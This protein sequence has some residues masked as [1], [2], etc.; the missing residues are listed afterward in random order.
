MTE[1]GKKTSQKHSKFIQITYFANILKK[2][3]KKGKWKF[4]AH[5]PHRHPSNNT[6]YDP[7]DE[8]IDVASVDGTSIFVSS[9]ILLLW[10]TAK[11]Q[12][13]KKN[14]KNEMERRTREKF[15]AKT[16]C[17]VE[18]YNKDNSNNNNN[19]DSKW[20]PVWPM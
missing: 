14:H 3:E 5:I 20:L 4:I 16:N 11:W 8:N 10:R 7:S 15:Q 13:Q 12:K 1:T 19:D 17:I 2:I 6:I 9:N 18:M